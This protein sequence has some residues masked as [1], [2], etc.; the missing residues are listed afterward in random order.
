[1][2]HT[3]T[4]GKTRPGLTKR[5]RWN[6]KI[7]LVVLGLGSSLLFSSLTFAVFQDL[8]L[9]NRTITDQ[10]TFAATQS[11]TAAGQDAKQQATNFSVASGAEVTFRAGKQ[12]QLQPG[13]QVQQGGQFQALI[14]KV[15]NIPPTLT[16]LEPDG[17][18]DTASTSYTISWQDADPD[19]DAPIALY[20]DTDNT[21]Q[22]G[23]LI[24]EDLSEDA[25]E[26]S[27]EWDTSE[28]PA[29]DYYIYGVIKDGESA[30]VISYSPGPVTLEPQTVTQTISLNKGWNIMGH[31]VT[32][33]ATDLQSVVQPL[34]KEGSLVKM[35][36]EQ[37]KTLIYFELLGGWINK[38][39]NLKP[40]E[41][42]ALK[43]NQN[44]ELEITGTPL[45]LPFTIPLQ[46]GWNILNYPSANPQDALGVVQP[47]IDAGDL[48]KVIDQQGKTLIYFELLGGWINQI[49]NFKSGEGYKIKVQRK[50]TLTIKKS[51]Q[52]A[53]LL[54]A[55]STFRNL[56]S[57]TKERAQTATHFTPSWSGQPYNRMNLWLTKATLNGEDLAPGDEIGIFDREQCVGVGRITARLSQQNYLTITASQDDGSGQGFRKGQEISLKIWDQSSQTEIVSVALSVTD[58]NNRGPLTFNGDADYLV[59]L[60]ANQAV[61]AVNTPPSLTILEPDGTED[62]AST[63]YTISW[64][65]ADP[66]NDAQIA[67]Y[68]D[69]DNTG[70]DGT[71]IVE[72]LS[73]DAEEDAYEW[74]TTA[75]PAGDYYIYGVIKDRVNS[76]VTSYSSGAVTIRQPAENTPPSL[77]ILEPDGTEDR[78]DTTYT[79]SWE[80]ADPE[81][82]ATLALYYDK[83]NSGADGTLIVENLSEDAEEDAYEWATTAVPAGDYYIY[84]V[85]KDRVN[86]AV[87]S[88]SSGAVTIRQPAENTPPSLTILEP[89]GTEDR[90]DTTYTISWEDADPEENATLALYYDKDNSGADGTLIVENLEEDAATDTYTWAT[91]ALPAG[92]YYIYGVIKDRVNPAVVSYSRGPVKLEPQAV[93][94]PIPLSKGWNILNY[95]SAHPQEALDVMQSLIKEGSLVKVIDEQGKTLVYFELLGGWINQIGNFKPGESYKIKVQ[96]KTTLTINKSQQ[97]AKLD[98]ALSTFRNLLSPA[99][100]RAPTA[101]H[102]T[103]SWTGQPHNRLNLWVPKATLNGEDLAPGDE[104]GI[105]DGKQCV[106]V[107]RV[108]AR[109]SQQ[110]YL[111][112]T[113]SQDEGSG[114]GF[115][116][117]QKITLKIWD[118]SS[119]T[120][121]VS[122]AL[123]VPDRNN[124]GPLIFSGDADYLVELSATRPAQPGA[125]ESAR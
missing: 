53:K 66:D 64:Q 121:I 15:V 11:L 85:I 87:T 43:V 107:G 37:G 22:D 80:D 91:A 62:T 100:E 48:V 89:D 51:Q 110:N 94:Q 27:Y 112:I 59:E 113:A 82:N 109:L 84:G 52:Q 72:D 38:I 125:E 118:E 79:I 55:L 117:G 26:D 114:Q 99:K 60:S 44:T 5:P 1:M 42:Y 33:A 65:A 17:K 92:T 31:Y 77:T 81:E 14:G 73:E 101:T 88:Y 30:D 8:L 20:Y 68:Y 58:R 29:G 67:L 57:P 41:G 96:R 34:I 98:R 123:S 54:R 70:Q 46:K 18:E 105:F 97:Q 124:R 86:S 9:Q 49:G 119:Q 19:N 36:D 95:P 6:R 23:T 25:E 56:L 35:I 12:M 74:A 63:S 32:P 111:I 108:T 3:L 115:R 13:F 2:F 21:G 75:V 61:K 106:G 50:T 78:A 90:A 104:I 10:Q 103:P 71:L 40:T 47:L 120:E 45:E 76:A 122:A 116:K 69:T 7:R 4:P 102:F 24:V 16:L 93:N 28:I 83:D 39:G